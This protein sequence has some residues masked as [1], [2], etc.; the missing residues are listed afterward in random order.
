MLLAVR[1]G[2]GRCAQ[3]C[4]GLSFALMFFVEIHAKDKPNQT[5]LLFH[6]PLD[7]PL[8]PPAS[9]PGVFVFSSVQR[10]LASVGHP[11]HPGQKQQGLTQLQ[12]VVMVP[13]GS[14]SPHFKSTFP[15]DCPS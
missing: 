10:A 11:Y 15:S 8:A 7:P 3:S 12:S 1:G 2:G 14:G 9:G 4:A 13:A 5:C 6:L